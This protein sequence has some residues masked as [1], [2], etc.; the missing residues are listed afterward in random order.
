MD[1]DTGSLF[2]ALDDF[3]QGEKNT[4]HLNHTLPMLVIQVVK[5]AFL[6]IFFS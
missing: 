5:P 1:G 3:V 6:P 4:R 2:E